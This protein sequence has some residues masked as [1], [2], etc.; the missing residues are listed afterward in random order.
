MKP[1]NESKNSESPDRKDF[2]RHA[3]QRICSN[4]ETTSTPSWRRSLD[5]KKILC[6][7]CGLYQKLHGKSRQLSTTVD[8]KKRIVKNAQDRMSCANCG[9]VDS[10]LWRNVNGVPFCNSCGGKS[11]SESAIDTRRLKF[12]YDIVDPTRNNKPLYTIHDYDSCHYNTLASD[13]SVNDSEDFKITDEQELNI[14][15]QNDTLNKYDFYDKNY[16]KP[17]KIYNTDL[18]NP[19]ETSLKSYK[20]NVKSHQPI[21]TS[22]NYYVKEKYNTSSYIKQSLLNKKIPIPGYNEKLKKYNPDN[23]D[24]KEMYKNSGN[25][26][27]NEKNVLRANNLPNNKINVITENINKDTSNP[28]FKIYGNRYPD[29]Q[30]YFNNH[31]DYTCRYSK[32]SEQ[33]Y[34]SGISGFKL[35][36]ANDFYYAKLYSKLKFNPPKTDNEIKNYTS[37]VNNYKKGKVKS[38]VNEYTY[39]N[40]SMD[41]EEINIDS[42]PDN[43]NDINKK[44]DD[45]HENTNYNREINNNINKYDRLY[46]KDKNDN[47][48]DQISEYFN[49]YF[50]DFYDQNLSENLNSGKKIQEKENL[51]KIHSENSD[52]IELP[53][54]KGEI[55]LYDLEEQRRIENGFIRHVSMVDKKKTNSFESYFSTSSESDDYLYLSKTDR[56]KKDNDVFRNRVTD[57][58]FSQ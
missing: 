37:Y 34:K 22:F 23:S 10:E 46:E 51:Y 52:E 33:R 24:F 54:I 44:T 6:N 43:L 49:K 30:Y 45:L 3:I 56:F 4:C 57:D 26:V 14:L 2:R 38:T 15:K 58:E 47:L 50:D 8:G 11:F 20:S 55:D 9:S 29:P 31:N 27:Y 40:Q 25:V 41:N 53:D 16:S 13:A 36:S 12:N 17:D 18:L 5:R 39:N 32:N 42:I 48:N 1:E 28:L 21:Q 7:A 19:N 35:E